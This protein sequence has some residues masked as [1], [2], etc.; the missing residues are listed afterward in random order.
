M[1]MINDFTKMMLGSLG[2]EE[3]WDIEGAESERPP[4]KAGGRSVPYFKQPSVKPEGMA[5]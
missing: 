4:A 5:Q 3:P 2:L 1:E